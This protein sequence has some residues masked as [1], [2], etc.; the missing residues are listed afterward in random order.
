MRKKNAIILLLAVAG[1]CIA[2]V[3]VL[4]TVLDETISAILGRYEADERL[5]FGTAFLAQ[6]SLALRE[7]YPFNSA[8]LKQT[9]HNVAAVEYRQKNYATAELVYR[10]LIDLT[11]D[12]YYQS[13][14][15][16]I[17]HAEGKFAEAEKMYQVALRQRERDY[18]AEPGRYNEM[19]ISFTLDN[20]GMLEQDQR[21][22]QQALNYFCRSFELREKT[23]SSYLPVSVEHIGSV[24][25]E[26]GKLPQAEMAYKAVISM[27]EELL[28]DGKRTALPLVRALNNEARVL[29]KMGKNHEAQTIEERCREL[30]KQLTAYDLRKV[31]DRVIRGGF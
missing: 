5:P 18:A 11:G 14:L 19:A 4:P 23:H 26:S 16:Q 1:I 15:A 3:F 8:A 25:E 21:K 2:A 28:A 27:E 29:C 30:S 24:Y 20:L 13:G 12:S 9:L 10:R 6:L 31:D 7:V 17:H 22:Y